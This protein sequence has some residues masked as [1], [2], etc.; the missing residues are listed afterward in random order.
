[1]I[2]NYIYIWYVVPQIRIHDCLFLDRYSV[3][4][5]RHK[6]LLEENKIQKWHCLLTRLNRLI[7]WVIRLYI[8][9]LNR[10][11][12]W[13][14]RLYILLEK[15]YLVR[16][17]DIR[18]LTKWRAC[19]VLEDLRENSTF[20]GIHERWLTSSSDS[21]DFFFFAFIVC[22]QRAIRTTYHFPYFYICYI[23]CTL[24]LLKCAFDI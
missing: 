9:R 7:N 11:I 6:T 12:N 8:L 1:L 18:N 22:C 24:N 17:G 5:L 3:L 2:Q 14:I 19:F 23:K 16:D 20:G 15:C 10:L 21:I 4:E 13:V